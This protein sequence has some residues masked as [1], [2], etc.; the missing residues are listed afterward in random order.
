MTNRTSIDILEEAVEL[1]R[2]ASI[3]TAATYLIG[4][5]PLTLGFLFFLADMNRSPYAY[6][7][8]PWA[9]L[10]LAILYVWKNSWQAIFMAKLYHQ[11]SPS[12][13]SR[14]SPWR[15]VLMQ[16]T[17][18]PVGLVIPLPFPWITA[19]FRNVALYAGLG[20]PDAIRAA[21]RQSVYA[22]RQNWGVLVIVGLG[23][24]LLLANVLI[25]IVALPQLARSLL[26]IEGDLVRLGMGILNLTTFGVALAVV[27]FAVDPLLDAVY[28]L[29]CFYG[30]SVA[31]GADLRAAVKRAVAVLLFA[32]T[33]I[34]A[35][36]IDE[37]KLDQAI[38]QVV[39]QREFTWRAPRPAGAEPDGKWVGWYRG[40]VKWIGEAWDWTIQKFLDWIQPTK[41]SGGSEKEARVNRKAMLALIVVIVAFIAAGLVVYFLRRKKVA[42]VAAQAVSAAPAVNLADESLT[43]D[44][45]PESE[46]LALAE[47][48]MAKG[49]FRFAL[50]AMYL[51]ALN[52]L[53]ARE[54][55]SLR[56]WKS[57]LDYRRELARRARSNPELALEFSRGV[58]IFEQ[59]WYGQHTVDRAM[60]ESLAN[61]FRE[62]RGR[63]Q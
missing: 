31:S 39:H 50:R 41:E 18:Q 61:G 46:W 38:D 48:W 36:T 63:A 33:S 13:T 45:L 1:L 29:R 26:G 62:M 58:A 60:A 35:Q 44:R 52:H 2:A 22:T 51:A 11:L 27:W 6:E 16:S 24:L 19:F 3:E 17:L 57:G 7:H 56:R 14:P 53:S 5:V 49:D 9:S 55:V 32:I 43:A 4:A 40:A 30:E 37:K 28:V 8:L 20:R 34:H 21:R 59:G 54:L 42:V 15:A 10:A 47:E 23:A 12:E 25:A